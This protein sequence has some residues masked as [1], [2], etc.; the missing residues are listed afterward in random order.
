MVCYFR[1]PGPE[2]KACYSLV[3]DGMV[4]SLLLSGLLRGDVCVFVLLVIIF[5]SVMC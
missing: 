3:T 5:S 2:R 1:E 4:A